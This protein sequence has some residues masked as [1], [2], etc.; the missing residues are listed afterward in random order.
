MGQNQPSLQPMEMEDG[1][2]WSWTMFL[3][4]L[5]AGLVRELSLATFTRSRTGAHHQPAAPAAVCL[6]AQSNCLL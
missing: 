2:L 1:F 4:R 5:V 6:E 3:A